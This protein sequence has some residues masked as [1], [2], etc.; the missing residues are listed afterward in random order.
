MKIKRIAQMGE[1][2][3]EEVI[4]EILTR[5]R[6]RGEGFLLDKEISIRAGL[7]RNKRNRYKDGI[8]QA[9]IEKLENQ[10]RVFN[11]RDNSSP[12]GRDKWMLTDSEYELRRNK[13]DTNEKAPQNP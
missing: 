1:S 5:A 2:L 12:Y 10:D 3:L 9:L 8:V 7:Y 13:D 11:G 4:L 6:R